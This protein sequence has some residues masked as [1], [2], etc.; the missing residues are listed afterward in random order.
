MYLFLPTPRDNSE[1]QFD[2]KSPK[3]KKV[4][5]F[6]QTFCSVL[7]RCLFCLVVQK[8]VFENAPAR[9]ESGAHRIE[10]Q[11]SFFSAE[12]VTQ[13]VGNRLHKR[14]RY[15]PEENGLHLCASFHFL[16][17]ERNMADTSDAQRSHEDANRKL[18]KPEVQPDSAVGFQNRK[19]TG[20]PQFGKHRHHKGLF[21]L[22]EKS[23]EKDISGIS[24]KSTHFT[25][26]YRNFADTLP[27][28]GVFLRKQG[29]LPKQC[30]MQL[31]CH[32]I[33]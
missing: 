19:T 24:Q 12:E 11:K 29:S 20:F 3:R 14:K 21:P 27:T 4:F 13:E 8:T 9:K 33:K 16:P 5:E 31:H 25:A 32:Q 23:G 26:G 2:E 17:V 7:L 15:T 28:S 18:I 6:V 30:N 1:D 10:F 22:G